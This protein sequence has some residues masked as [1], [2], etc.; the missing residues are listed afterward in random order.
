M[1]HLESIFTYKNLKCVVVLQSRGHRCGYVGIPS[2][3]PLF[4]IDMNE[5]INSPTLLDSLR[6]APLGKRGIIPCIGWDAKSVTLEILFDVH[7]GITYSES[8]KTYLEKLWWFGFDC[9]HGEDAND[10]EAVAKIFSEKEWKT[11]YEIDK[12]FPMDGKVRTKEY[13]ENECK[14]LAEQIIEVENLLIEEA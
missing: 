1:R 12:D 3:H 14:N 9:A 11:K 5:S 13:V 7:G 4:G 6:K 8:S 10:W 2:N